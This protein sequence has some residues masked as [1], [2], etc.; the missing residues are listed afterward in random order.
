MCVDI[1]TCEAFNMPPAAY[2]P[3]LD[4]WDALAAISSRTEPPSR[5]YLHESLTNRTRVLEMNIQYYQSLLKLT[6]QELSLAGPDALTTSLPAYR[7]SVQTYLTNILDRHRQRALQRELE[8]RQKRINALRTTRLAQLIEEDMR[9][10]AAEEKRLA[11]LE[12]ADREARR[13]RAARVTVTK[14]VYFTAVVTHPIS[15]CI[16]N[17]YI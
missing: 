16:Y 7:E 12:A 11:A 17:T 1:S 14:Q 5:Q 3:E 4:L 2:L 13:K 6:Q 8:S 15:T 9:K 10:K